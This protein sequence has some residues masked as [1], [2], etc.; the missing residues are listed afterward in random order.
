MPDRSSDFAALRDA[1]LKART[2]T[3]VAQSQTK[4][5]LKAD[6]AATQAWDRA[7]QAYGDAMLQLITAIQ[8]V[9]CFPVSSNTGRAFP[10]TADDRPLVA[11]F[12][13][14]LGRPLVFVRKG[15]PA[16]LSA[17]STAFVAEP[18]SVFAA[19]GSVWAWAREQAALLARHGY[20]VWARPGPDLTQWE[21]LHLCLL[22][23]TAELT[24]ARAARF[25]FTALAQAG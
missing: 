14:L 4:E 11:E 13:E 16:P 9:R 18:A 24:D 21:E 17:S 7:H 12:P 2:A 23:A 1:L 3:A 19:D 25:G 20:G 22:L 8:W 5:N 10:R 6:K 15:A